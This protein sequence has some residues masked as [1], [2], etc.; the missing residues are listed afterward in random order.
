M[1]F[2]NVVSLTKYIDEIRLLLADEKIDLLAL[3]ETRLDYSTTNGFVNVIGY[4]IIRRDRN[5]CG[6]GV[7]IYVRKS[8]TYLERP[9]LVPEGLEAVCLEIKNPKS[10]PFIVSTIYRPPS[11]SVDIFNKIESLVE[12][13]DN[14][15]LEVNILGDLNANLLDHAS[16]PAKKL[17]LIM[18]HYQLSQLID[19]PT[20]I[21]KYS[22]T[23]LDVCIVSSPEKIIHSGIIPVG[24]SDHSLIYSVRK[25]NMLPKTKGIREIEIRNFKNFDSKNFLEDLDRQHWVQVESEREVNAMWTT[26]RNLFLGVLDKHA[27]LRSKR[28]KNNPNLPWISKEIKKKMRER[29]RLKLVAIKN[30]KEQ[31]WKLYKCSRNEVNIALRKAKANYYAT[32]IE[33]QNQN[34]KHAWKIVNDILGRKQKDS[35][36]TEI[37]FNNSSITSADEIANHFNDYFTNIGLALAEGIDNNERVNFNDFVN[38]SN[39]NFHFKYTTEAKVYKLLCSLSVSKSTGIDNIPARVLKLSAPV[40]SQ[41]LT[42]I[43][44]ASIASQTFP[45]EWKIAR[46]I[47]LHK[48]GP[49]DMLDNYRPISILPV[50]SKIYEKILYEQLIEYLVTENILSDHQFGFRRQ[51]STASALLDSTNEWYMNMDRG[52]FNLV[53]FL[54][55]KKA[56]DTVN[57]EILLAKLMAYGVKGSSLNLISS[58]LK[59]RKQTCMVNGSYSNQ[60]RISCGIPQGSIL[61]PLFF[62][63]YI[64]DLP[65]CLSFTTPRMFA[66]DTNITVAGKSVTETQTILN[67]DLNSIKAWLVANKLSLNIA[68]TEYVLV[69]SRNRL[70]ELEEPDIVI[71]NEPVK[72][73]Q[74]TKVLGVHIDENLTWDKHID[75]VAKKVSSGI[76]AIRKLKEFVNQDTLVSVYN[77]LLRPHFEYCSV[78]WD[79]LGIGLSDRLQRLQNRCARVIMR[80]PNETGQSEIAMRSLG[81]TTLSKRRAQIKAELL[82]KIFHNL[83]PRRLSSL[84]RDSYAASSN[85]CLRDSSN[86]VALPLPKTE[87]LKKSLSYDGAKLWN[88]LPSDVRHC[89]CP[90][91]FRNKLLSLGL[92]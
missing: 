11:A 83:A 39:G 70:S 77:A 20:R 76:S 15:D 63:L 69:G 66:D 25:I 41:S 43:F 3:N 21:T 67:H 10:R 79:T 52:L 84:F 64:N 6:G 53:V 35:H 65:N 86:K 36:I 12:Q 29:D 33:N 78:V 18:E 62:L 46:I 90:V 37:K 87:F 58:Y 38:K 16:S 71:G 56:F 92:T 28:V 85:Y 34:P 45:S 48:K 50:I 30:S 74:S 47:P 44:N 23:L 27:P 14:L 91:S 22:S 49:R 61:G 80:C 24:F 5:R 73:V 60:G 13:I 26:W 54:D 51:H 59:D 1:A 72:R 68:K 8:L 57:H 40:I 82:F 9:D 32:Q 88:S 89:E 55:L 75:V 42:K 7:C 81:W 17:S 2:L 19:K 4:D 31:D